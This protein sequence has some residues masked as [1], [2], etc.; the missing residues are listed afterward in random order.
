MAYLFQHRDIRSGIRVGVAGI[1]VEVFCR[2][3]PLQ[4][5]CFIGALAVKEH[6]PGK[7]AVFLCQFGGDDVLDAEF[8]CDDVHQHGR[9]G[10]DDDHVVASGAVGADKFAGLSINGGRDHVMHG[11]AG[12]GAHLVHRPPGDQC[13]ELVAGGIHA[14]AG[15]TRKH[16]AGLSK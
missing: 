6:L 16:I 9:G 2:C 14:F 5:L 15:Q 13:G 3:G 10:R 4:G 11:V 1:K 8:L 12:D 7:T